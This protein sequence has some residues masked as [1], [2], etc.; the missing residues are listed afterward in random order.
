ML[1]IG[2][3]WSVFL[4]V[5]NWPAW[6]AREGIGNVPGAGYKMVG[7]NVFRIDTAFWGYSRPRLQAMGEAEVEQLAFL[8]PL[9]QLVPPVQLAPLVTALDLEQPLSRS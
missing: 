2:L 3:A 1:L 9:V 6:Q 7:T 4:S 5:P 8:T